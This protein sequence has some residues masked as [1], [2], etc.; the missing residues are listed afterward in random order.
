MSHSKDT[1]NTTRISKTKNIEKH[2]NKIINSNFIYLSL[3]NKNN[4]YNK[5]KYGISESNY[6]KKRFLLYPE[7]IINPKEYYPYFIPNNKY[8]E[9]DVFCYDLRNLT[10]DYKKYIKYIPKNETKIQFI[11]TDFYYYLLSILKEKGFTNREVLFEIFNNEKAGFTCTIFKVIYDLESKQPTFYFNFYQQYKVAK[12]TDDQREMIF[13]EFVRLSHNYEVF[14]S[15]TKKFNKKVNNSQ[16]IFSI[17]NFYLLIRIIEDCLLLLFDNNINYEK[18]NIIIDDFFIGDDYSQIKSYEDFKI[19]LHMNKKAFY[20]IKFLCFY[21]NQFIYG[22]QQY[23]EY[24]MPSDINKVGEYFYEIGEERLYLPKENEKIFDNSGNLFNFCEGYEKIKTL[25]IHSIGNYYIDLFKFCENIYLFL[26]NIINY[27]EME[28]IMISAYRNEYI[29]IFYGKFLYNIFEDIVKEDVDY[30]P[31]T[32]RNDEIF[33][34]LLCLPYLSF[35]FKNNRINI[36]GPIYKK[37]IN[38]IILEEKILKDMNFFSVETIID[39]IKSG[40]SFEKYIKSLFEYQTA[41]LYLNEK[42]KKYYMVSKEIKE[43]NTINFEYIKAKVELNNFNLFIIDQINQN[44]QFFDFLFIKIENSHVTLYFIQISSK[45]SEEDL[46]KIIENIYFILNKYKNIIR[47]KKL[48]YKDAFFYLISSQNLKDENIIKY[49]IK[50]DL[51]IN[52]TFE[53]KRKQFFYYNENTLYYPILLEEFP[54]EYNISELTK[55]Y[56]I[57]VLW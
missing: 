30:I 3:L 44:G 32:R 50:N 4:N 37:I 55:N 48:V 40:L 51:Y 25:M 52:I 57:I 56:I 18:L 28:N 11:Y 14:C 54:E 35:D 19:D 15:L 46:K 5:M 42:I 45:K 21:N 34:K 33:S 13:N 41:K 23:L 27:E 6:N 38:K 2:I 43:P 10:L 49:C 29:K 20:L 12:T 22:S 8:K 47:E 31:Y 17:N 24:K 26:N 9:V 7:E 16:K 53:E 36:L 39:K 1:N